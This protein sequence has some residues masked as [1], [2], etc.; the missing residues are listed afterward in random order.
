METRPE[1]MNYPNCVHSH[2]SKTDQIHMYTYIHT[3]LQDWKSGGGAWEQG[4]D[5]YS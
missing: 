3:L 1:L 2:F 5:W 4:Y